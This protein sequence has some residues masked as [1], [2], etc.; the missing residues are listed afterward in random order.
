MSGL[1]YFAPTDELSP[2]DN[3]GQLNSFQNLIL[4]LAAFNRSDIGVEL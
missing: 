4:T 1:I 3:G 2:A